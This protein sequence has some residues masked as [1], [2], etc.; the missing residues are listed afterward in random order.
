MTIF[1][2]RRLQFM[3]DELAPVLTDGKGKDLLRRL[4]SKKD[5]DQALPAE[6]EL[7]LL[8]GIGSLGEME[9]EP[10][11]WG[12]SKRPDAITD[13]LVPRI[14]A[15]IEI[16]ATNDNSLS[17]EAEMDAI[18]LQIGAAA[19]RAQSGT[20]E[21]LYYHF[22]V[23]SGYEAGKYYRRRLAPK[24]FKVDEA[25][26]AAIA[27]WINSG[28][29]AN[30]R[31]H[32]QGQGLDVEVERKTYKQT[33]YHNI[34]SSMPVEAHSV[35]DNPLFELLRR[36]KRQLKAAVQGTLR[37]LFVADVGSSLLNHM[38]KFGWRDP[39]GRTVSGADVIG[40][41]VR[42]Y[43]ADIDAVVVFSPTIERSAWLGSDP[44]GREPKRWTVTFFGTAQLPQSPIGL[45][46]LAS[47]LPA[48]H[49][50]GYQARSLFRQGSFAPEGRGQYL[51]MTVTTNGKENRHTI[52][53]PARL[54]L[55]LLAGRI[56]EEWFRKYLTSGG[57]NTNLFEHWLNMGMTL[58]GAEI[59]P[60]SLD[61]DDD[62]IVLHFSDDPAARQFSLKKE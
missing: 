31:L 12:D 14:T 3:L 33:R 7:A 22:R 6:M 29:S 59:S 40:H 50:E 56:S 1:S 30:G 44:L 27:Q 13:F 34:F 17:G 62:H 54:L 26:R 8:W 16:A 2:R 15:A 51:G 52:A 58:S 23:T 41:F 57:R 11:W 39:A 25:M 18:A 37:L 43:S 61:E 53:F 36:K 48:P 35:D 46:R 9:I 55:D 32:L 38:G 19:N 45:E 21:Y 20:G 42:T 24:G 49:Y 4:N 47:I 10:E 5:V 60:R 28:L